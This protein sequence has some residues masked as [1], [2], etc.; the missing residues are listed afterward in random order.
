[1]SSPAVQAMLSYSEVDSLDDSDIRVLTP[2]PR[3][4]TPILVEFL[5]P[6]GPGPN[7]SGASGLDSGVSAALG[8]RAFPATSSSGSEDW[9][10]P[11]EIVEVLP[12]RHERPPVI[13]TL[14]DE[15]PPPL[16]PT[17]TM[18]AERRRAA[19]IGRRAAALAEAEGGGRCG[20]AE[21]RSGK[22]RRCD[23][24]DEA[25]DVGSDA[26]RGK[27]HRSSRTDR[28]SRRKERR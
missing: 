5:S 18:D 16:T 23:G 2:P 22:R 8:R 6:P 14:S 26:A 28:E 10:S 25:D 1:M 11:V 4:R 21:K 20:G 9:D 19:L 13:V 24:D 7:G 3:A 17:T 12:P 15:E 27:K